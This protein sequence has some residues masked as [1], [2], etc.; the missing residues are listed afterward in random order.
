MPLDTPL[1]ISPGPERLQTRH[2]PLNHVLG[3]PT[4]HYG[5]AVAPTESPFEI[6][7]K[8]TDSANSSVDSR[9]TKRVKRDVSPPRKI[10]YAQSLF[11]ATL[12]LSAVPISSAPPRPP[13]N[14]TGRRQAQAAPLPEGERQEE[15]DDDEEEE[16]E[17]PLIGGSSGDENLGELNPAIP[18][19]RA[20]PT[21]TES[22]GREG[23]PTVKKT[24]PTTSKRFGPTRS[25]ETPE[26]NMLKSVAQETQFAPRPN[27]MPSVTAAVP[28]LAAS[29]STSTN[30]KPKRVSGNAG[31]TRIADT[32]A[33]NS[34][35][36]M[37]DDESFEEMNELQASEYQ[38]VVRAE[39]VSRPAPPA[40]AKKQPKRRKSPQ[41]PPPPEPKPTIT[42]S[43]GAEVPFSEERTEIRLKPRRKRGLLS[44][45][46]KKTRAKQPKANSADTVKETVSDVGLDQPTSRA[47]PALDLHDDADGFLD[48]PHG[49]L[50]DTGPAIS[51]HIA[52]GRQVPADG[53]DEVDGADAA[54]KTARRGGGPSDAVI[55][56]EPRSAVDGLSLISTDLEAPSSAANTTCSPHLPP[57]RAECL[58]EANSLCLD[59]DDRSEAELSAEPTAPKAQRKS[60]KSKRLGEQHSAPPKKARRT[61][62]VS[63]VDA[64]EIPPPPAKPRLAR[65]SKRSVKSREVFGFVPSSPVPVH[66]GLLAPPT[67]GARPVQ[68]AADD[69]LPSQAP[70][71]PAAPAKDDAPAGQAP[72]A[73]EEPQTNTLPEPLCSAKPSTEQRCDAWQAAEGFDTEEHAGLMTPSSKLLA[74]GNLAGVKL[75]MPP[76]EFG[77]AEDTTETHPDISG[78]G[79]DITCKATIDH[80]V[81][82]HPHPQRPAEELLGAGDDRT[83]IGGGTTDRPQEPSA[84]GYSRPRIAN[85]ATRGRKAALKSDAAGQAPQPVIPLESVQ[86]HISVQIPTVPR[87]Q[88]A[89]ASERP[90]RKMRFP[91]FTSA[92]EGGGPWSREAHDLLES[93]RPG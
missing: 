47:V 51:G 14:S 36:I 63:R 87:P 67:F 27:A 89:V 78:L 72:P 92:K 21:V 73:V 91:G 32:G 44:V 28:E 64:Q 59:A 70:P 77:K 42:H 40:K 1:G 38:K 60:R 75:T 76:G 50:S 7:R 53:F 66:P 57:L 41:P 11:G 19:A 23:I 71:A 10:G 13:P 46:E 79:I 62:S 81:Q 69:E 9:P 24:A 93:V 83:K 20:G 29:R 26:V 58:D 18:L 8:T 30:P 17:G 48:A 88:T 15:E 39:S 68:F 86:G 65:L 12:S 85:P 37:V 55:S 35:A 52:S 34:Q 16:G 2:R 56:R 22:V 25:A 6:R 31:K 45:L 54:D 4:G 61:D 90:K 33:S 43:K 80:E 74:G 5:R 82:Q 3:T 84:A 49:I